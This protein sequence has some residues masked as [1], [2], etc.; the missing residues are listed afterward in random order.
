LE[1]L[2]N[3]QYLLSDNGL[4]VTI[5]FILNG[6]SLTF[7]SFFSVLDVVRGIAFGE[8]Q[9][10]TADMVFDEYVFLLFLAEKIILLFVDLDRL[11]FERLRFAD[12]DRLRDLLRLNLRRDLGIAMR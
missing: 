11:R 3:L 9:D 5:S 10:G 1:I 12:F 8:V 4:V 6:H 2:P 7:R